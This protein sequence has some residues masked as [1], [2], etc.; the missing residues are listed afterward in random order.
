VGSSLRTDSQLR[1]VF[2]KV[3]TAFIN[4]QEVTL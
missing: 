1:V 2:I 3:T 4:F